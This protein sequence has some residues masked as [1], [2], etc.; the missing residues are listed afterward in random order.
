MGRLKVRRIE[1]LELT[2]PQLGRV[3]VSG[4]E[5]L[6]LIVLQLEENDNEEVSL[7]T[8]GCWGV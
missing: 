3:Q 4:I 1:V 7:P 8:I 2:V 5:I 6:E